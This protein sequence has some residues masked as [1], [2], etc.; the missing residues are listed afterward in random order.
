MNHMLQYIQTTRPLMIHKKDSKYQ[1]KTGQIES[2]PLS[3]SKLKQIKRILRNKRKI[4]NLIFDE[5]N[6]IR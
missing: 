5:L 1:R 3:K 6:E 4:L 2:K